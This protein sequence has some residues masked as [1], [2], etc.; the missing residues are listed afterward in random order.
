MTHIADRPQQTRNPE[1]LRRQQNERRDRSAGARTLNRVDVARPGAK[2]AGERQVPLVDQLR[3]G[4]RN[5][6]LNQ[7]N[8]VRGMNQSEG[9]ARLDMNVDTVRLAYISQKARLDDERV[10]D[11]MTRSQLTNELMAKAILFAPHASDALKNRRRHESKEVLSQYND[12]MGEIVR[13]LPSKLRPG[14]KTA[15]VEALKLE[16]LALNQRIGHSS[17]ISGKDRETGLNELA[18]I[19]NGVTYEIAPENGLRGDPLLEVEIPKDTR[20]D[21]EGIDMIVK[22]KEDGKTIL[23]DTK[24]RGSYLSTVGDYQGVDWVEESSV[25]PYFFTEMKTM[26]DGSLLPH[27]LLNANSFSQIP[28]EG[29][30]YT[31]VGQ[32]KLRR[33]VH[34]MLDQ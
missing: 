14:Y 24:T 3:M 26:D 29:F 8:N 28:S 32:E 20:S 17:E 7:L 12:I 13:S 5:A 23:I 19:M 21:L 30:D 16:S 27:Y 33:T 10:T 6:A 15:V 4:A 1:H 2:P 18:T 22:R 31:P 34:Q 9:G 25:G 11:E